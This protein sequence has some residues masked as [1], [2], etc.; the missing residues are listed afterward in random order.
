MAEKGE[1]VLNLSSNIKQIDSPGKRKW[2]S[3]KKSNSGGLGVKTEFTTQNDI[4]GSENGHN[5][6]IKYDSGNGNV[7]IS[8]FKNFYCRFA[9]TGLELN[10]LVHGNL[11]QTST[12]NFN[13]NFTIFSLNTFSAHIENY[14]YWSRRTLMSE[15]LLGPVLIGQYTRVNVY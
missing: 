11:C 14:T 4:G 3:A 12:C 1:K 7:S 6:T 5:S 15:T 10:T 13:I 9:V 2:K 8:A